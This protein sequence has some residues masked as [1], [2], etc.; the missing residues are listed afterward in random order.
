MIA[1]VDILDVA[2]TSKLPTSKLL[3]ATILDVPYNTRLILTGVSLL[4]ASAAVIGAF[5]V[6]RQRALTGDALSHAALPGICLAYLIVGGKDFFALLLGAF[7]AGLA[8]V[9]V[10]SLLC[11]WTRLKED[12]AIGVVLGTFFGAGTVLLSLIQRLPGGGASGLDSFIFGQ[13]ANMN[14]ADVN[15]IAGLALATLVLV[16]AL[17]KEFKLT[18]F[19]PAFARVQGWPDFWLD[20]ALMVLIAL[21]VVIGLPAVG[22]VMMAALLII[23][24]VSARF[25]TDRLGILLLIAAA[26][27]MGMGV[28]G[29]LLSD[30]FNLPAG[31][32]IVLV[33]TGLF[34][35]S[36]LAAPRRGLL[37]KHL[38][39]RRFQ[40]QMEHR[41]LWLTLL[42]LMPTDSS[43]I[44]FDDIRGRGSWTR[45][46]LRRLLKKAE[47]DEMVQPQGN[48]GFLLSEK[49]RRQLH[50]V[51]R[52]QCLWEA[53]LQ[54][55]PDLAPA[56]ARFF[57]TQSPEDVLPADILH[58]LAYAALPLSAPPLAHAPGSAGSSLADASGSATPQEDLP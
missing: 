53:F 18:T 51:A 50:R 5:A 15:L 8:G 35:I 16:M 58:D 56:Y 25:W 49:G 20:I 23:P 39:Q 54:A 34:L 40:A 44:A 3:V 30:R 41:L 55:H 48:R 32:A 22:V 33:G 21:A 11:R 46:R 31:P 42:K 7:V 9:A 27:G 57:A 4:G 1:L 38:A 43:P 47:Q 52:D 45:P 19:D 2:A 29:A 28:A 24:P 26:F 6:L 12:A 14:R 10:I 37:A 36:A 17:Y 13:V